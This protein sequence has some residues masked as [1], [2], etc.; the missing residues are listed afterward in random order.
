MKQH[1]VILNEVNLKEFQDAIAPLY[2]NN[3]L[4]FSPGLKEKLFKQL[5]M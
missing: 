5:G 3:D 1:G 4:K 2:T